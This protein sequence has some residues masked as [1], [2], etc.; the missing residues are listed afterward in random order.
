MS[1]E[2]WWSGDWQGECDNVLPG[3]AI[4]EYGA[5]MEW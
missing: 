4:D 5:M 2:Q 1:I 3:R